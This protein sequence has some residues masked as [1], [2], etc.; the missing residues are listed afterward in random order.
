MTADKIAN[1]KPR[2][3]EVL[4]LMCEGLPTKLISARLNL[5]YHTVAEYRHDL[6]RHFGVAN[7]V[8]L[9]NKINQIK[10]ESR[11]ARNPDLQAALESP[12]CLLVV[13]D[14]VCYRELV[15]ADL[16]AM[17]FPCRGVGSRAEMEAA[18]AGQ[19]VSIVLLDLNL[20]AEDGLAIARDLR[21]TQ[22]LLGII[23]MTTR[24]MVEQRIEGLVVGADVYLVKPVDMRELASVIRNL[25]RR[26]VECQAALPG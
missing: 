15:L 26:V 24:G 14:D 3:R 19:A 25:Y 9:V 23:M 13:E 18:L 12:P 21:E 4:E 20:G 5:S 2:L 16:E 22:P 10:A 11:L 7:A 8:E 6:L 17:G 1:L